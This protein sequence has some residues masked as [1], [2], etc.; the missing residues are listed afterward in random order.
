MAG[1]LAL[2][3]LLDH[4]LGHPNQSTVD[5]S[6]LK[7]FLLQFLIATNQA[8]F[9]VNAT[10]KPLGLP[11]QDKVHADVDKE[12]SQKALSVHVEQPV[13]DEKTSDNSEG[14]ESRI[15]KP[16][17]N[18]SQYVFSVY[19]KCIPHNVA[20]DLDFKVAAYSTCLPSFRPYYW[21]II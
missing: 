21:P 15:E 8:Q 14:D 6:L 10:G 1:Q 13:D 17:M 7:D 18:L 9:I 11:R 5:L 16:E 4:A 2:W 12:T 19:I 3:Q 20:V